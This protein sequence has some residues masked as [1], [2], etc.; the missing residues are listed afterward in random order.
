M[1]RQIGYNFHH[2]NG[3]YF[4][5]TSDEGNNDTYDVK[6]VDRDYDKVIYESEMNVNTWV[7]LNR[8]YL[9]NIVILIYHKDE[10]VAEL[11]ALEMLVGKRIFISFDSKSLGD[12]LAWMPCCD[13]FRKMLNCELI[14]STFRNELFEGQYPNIQFVGRGVKVENI[15]GMFELGWFYDKDREPENPL[16]T[17]LQG[18]AKNILY[19]KD[20]TEILPNL[21][22][23]IAER[24]I[25]EKYICISTHS[26]AQLKLWYYWQELIDM[27]NNEGYKIVEISNDPTDLT[28]LEPIA[29]KSIKSVLNYLYHCE[30]FIG[31]SSG[32]SW[33][34][35][36]M[37]K[38]VY[39]ISN[40]SKADHEFTTNCVRITKEDVCHGCWNEPKFRF[41]KGNW[42]YC[43][44]HED[45]PRQF[46]CHKSI[47]AEFV[48][49][50]INR[51]KHY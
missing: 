44:E 8:K 50:E 24:P 37:R 26:T 11:S 32:L 35:W 31:L 29:D 36:G 3:L 33:L 40:F 25:F 7:R 19:I 47:T 13:Y 1:T 51:T 15:I 18:A 49:N 20:K 30:F 23:E 38:K 14:V 41:D 45:T 22:Y 6:F 2:V 42:W 21:N 43:P 27:L 4:E 39:M 12:T 48:F 17:S 34:A 46:E 16:T 10:L 5:I 28:G 9:S